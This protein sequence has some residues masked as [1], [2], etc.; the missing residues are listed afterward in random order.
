MA[1]PVDYGPFVE[2]R[3][4]QCGYRLDMAGLLHGEEQKPEEGDASL[5]LNCGQILTY[6]ADLSLRQA[7]AAEIREWMGDAEG[8]AA[9][10]NSQRLI[11]QRGRFH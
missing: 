6:Q 7:T 9:I 8:W 1:E 10:E 5:C 2:S 4:P 11:R 3:C